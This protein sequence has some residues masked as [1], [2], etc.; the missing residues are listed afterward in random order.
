MSRPFPE[1][2]VE[3]KAK[4]PR[5]KALNIKEILFPRDLGINNGGGFK[6]TIMEF[7]LNEK[8][9][10]GYSVRWKFSETLYTGRTDYQHLAIIDT[11]EFGK[12]LVLDGIVQTTEKDEY[13]YHEM[14]AHPVLMTHPNPQKVLVIGGGDGGTIR[15]VVR[16][17]AVEQADLVEID[18]KVIW[19][20]QKYLPDISYALNDKRVRIL[21]EDGIKFVKNK[22]N[23]YDIIL[24]DSSDPIGP[25]AGLFQRDFYREIYSALKDDGILAAQTESPTFN[26]ELLSGV[27]KTIREIF[28]VTRT[29]LTAIATYIG[30]FWSFTCGSK[31]YDPLAVMPDSGRIKNMNLKYYNEEIHKAC[32]VLPNNIKQLFD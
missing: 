20:C 18:E 30:G 13:I 16:R 14:L 6:V 31:K 4:S 19:A 25:A 3:E 22:E 11:L 28:P 12:A 24:V 21:V 29:Y 1:P 23:Y 5:R 8:H 7:W 27:H 15:E 17:P 2:T 26:Q 9:T 32:F 10:E